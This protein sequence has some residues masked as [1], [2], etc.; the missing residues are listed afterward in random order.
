VVGLTFTIQNGREPQKLPCPRTPA[1]AGVAVSDEEHHGRV[2]TVNELV[3]RYLTNAS[4]CHADENESQHKAR[5]ALGFSPN[6]FNVDWDSLY[7]TLTTVSPSIFY[8]FSS[9]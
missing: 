9:I 2:E 6:P 7:E 3:L 1:Q 5:A 8:I 4:N